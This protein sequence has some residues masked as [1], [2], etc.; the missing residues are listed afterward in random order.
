MKLQRKSKYKHLATLNQSKKFKINWDGVPVFMKK[1]EPKNSLYNHFFLSIFNHIV[2][3]LLLWGLFSILKIEILNPIFKP[4]EKIKDI[5]FTL[6]NSSSHGHTPK[7]S[8]STANTQ[9]T[10]PINNN[11]NSSTKPTTNMQSNTSKFASIPI[12]SPDDF[13]IPTNKFKPASSSSGRLSKRLTNGSSEGLNPADIGTD[14]GSLNG[15]DSV[16]GKG[17]D[18][19]AA[20]K[21][22]TAYDMSPYV[23]ELKR[24]I[25][26]N[27]RPVKSSE[28]NYVELFLR[29]AKDGRLVILN[30]KKTSESGDVDDSALN[31]VK[32]TLPLSP[33]PSKYNKSFF[34]LVFTFNAS[35][36][37][38]GSRY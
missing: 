28:G 9:E 14:D 1:Y 20:R 19:N 22:V 16:K 12:A 37:T 4:K 35:S 33:L 18:K 27:W 8:K 32:K 36:S 29:I 31:A 23:S 11:L 24:N 10:T 25:R 3:F 13:S 38:L 7:L 26:M 34:D 17:F 5:E 15:S 21:A 6:N 2:L 30:V